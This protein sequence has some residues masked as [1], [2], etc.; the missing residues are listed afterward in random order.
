MK[1]VYGIVYETI[2]VPVIRNIVVVKEK[3][4][5]VEVPVY[6]NI[7]PRQWG[8]VDEFVEWWEA[9]EFKVLWNIDPE[10]NDCDDYSDGLQ[11]EALKQGYSV[12]QAL[13]LGGKYYGVVVVD[14]PTDHAGNMV[15]IGNTYYWV[16]PNPDEF[17]IIK[18]VDRD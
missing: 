4:V 1:T 15:L 14:N 10:N 12:S 16:E 7:L 13:A 3:L 11:M 5:P 9:Q 2:E 18:I 6:R 17:K 8:S